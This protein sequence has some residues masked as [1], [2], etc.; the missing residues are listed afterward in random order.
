M[1]SP[2]YGIGSISGTFWSGEGDGLSWSGD[3]I[4]RVSELVGC[5][6]LLRHGVL[7]YPKASIQVMPSPNL[8]IVW[9][10]VLKV[11]LEDRKL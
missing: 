5:G 4:C 8:R 1:E 3:L 10:V 7:S 9:P 6:V 2:K 11:K